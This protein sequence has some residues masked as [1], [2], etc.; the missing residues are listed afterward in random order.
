MEAS[1][2]IEKE[3]LPILVDQTRETLDKKISHESIEQQNVSIRVIG[4][5]LFGL[6]EILIKFFAHFATSNT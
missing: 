5:M 4:M 6:T 2:T 3:Q 1:E